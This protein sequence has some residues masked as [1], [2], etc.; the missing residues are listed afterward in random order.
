MIRELVLSSAV[1][2]VPLQTEFAEMT[3]RLQLKMFKV[4]ELANKYYSNMADENYDDL[5]N[6]SC[7][8]DVFNIE[9]D[10]LVA[11]VT[12][13]LDDNCD[14]EANK[15]IL[16]DGR[17]TITCNRYNCFT[18][19]DNFDLKFKKA[20]TGYTEIK[21]DLKPSDLSKLLLTDN[22][23][24]RR[25]K[26]ANTTSAK[27]AARLKEKQA[28]AAGAAGAEPAESDDFPIDSKY[29]DN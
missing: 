2:N 23:S 18:K 8:N 6:I 4:N 24:F 27:Y 20:A 5:A 28:P 11:N 25:F 19:V 16:T 21:Q 22:D 14:P 7:S 3:N 29:Q 15:Y 1:V 13:C 12:Y 26:E 17:I 10:N 9:L